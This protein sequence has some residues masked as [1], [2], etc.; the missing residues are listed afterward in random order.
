MASMLRLG[1]GLTS[2]EVYDMALGGNEKASRIFTVMGEALGI[3]LATMVNTFN[4]PLYL[5]SGGVLAAWDLFAPPMLEE[6]RRRSFAFRTTATRIEKSNA[7][8]RSRAVRRGIPALDGSPRQQT[9]NESCGWESMSAPAAR[10]RCWWT[11][12]AE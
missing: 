2:R 4:F 9:R 7:G 10:A 12:K 11:R 8:Q 1:D 6:M 3:A 5:L